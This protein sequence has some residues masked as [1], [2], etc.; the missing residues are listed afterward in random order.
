MLPPHHWHPDEGGSGDFIATHRKKEHILPFKTELHCHTATVSACAKGLPGEMAEHYIKLGY[1]AVV[2]TE[3]LSNATFKKATVGD[4][5]EAAWDEKIDYYMQGYHALRAAAGDR[6]TVIFGCELRRAAD[7]NDFLLY[8]IDEAFLRAHPDLHTYKVPALRDAVHEV[9]G[10]LIQA[11]PFRNGRR[12]VDPALLDGIEIFN[13]GIS[14]ENRNDIAAIWA[15][16]F[17]LLGTAG[18]DCHRPNG[19]NCLTG[20]LTDTPVRTGEDLVCHLREGSFT[21][22]E[23]LPPPEPRT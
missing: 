9:G 2:L 10:M 17:G 11:H 3:H 23:P 22:A 6:L 12:I 5:T 13:G 4:M 20:I 18:S 19:Y 21:L 14:N 1:D 7:G 15:E 16:H 8:G